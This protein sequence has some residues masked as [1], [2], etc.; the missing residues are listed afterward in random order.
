VTRVLIITS[1]LALLCTISAAQAPQR[2]DPK[3]E[4]QLK[5]LSERIAALE[6]AVLRDPL[7]PTRPVLTRV[8]SLERRLTTLEKR[9]ADTRDLTRRLTAI[10]D[11]QKQAARDAV[12][13]REVRDLQRKVD[14][15]TRTN[16]ELK[17]RMQRLESKR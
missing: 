15:L 2:P 8:E 1:L 6:K 5:T 12:D 17:Q 16:D 13:S 4:E 9:D 10:E 11:R 7:Q 3:L 14:Q